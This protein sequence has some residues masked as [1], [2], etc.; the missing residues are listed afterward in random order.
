MVDPESRPHSCPVPSGAE[1][2]PPAQLCVV[3]LQATGLDRPL[4]MRGA[5]PCRQT[6]HLGAPF[7]S[8][9]GER[10][11]PSVWYASPIV[12]HPSTSLLPP[13]AQRCLWDLASISFA[14]TGSQ[15]PRRPLWWYV[16]T[17]LEKARGV[18]TATGTLSSSRRGGQGKSCS[19][20][21]T[22]DDAVLEG[23]RAVNGPPPPPTRR[24]R[25][26]LPG[27]GAATAVCAVS[28]GRPAATD[29]RH[30]RGTNALLGCHRGI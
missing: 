28:G 10:R 13:L 4:P 15:W 22:G 7:P 17:L 18:P 6:P 11:R 19:V 12:A 23:K 14:R 9:I 20:R 21:A 2:P 8:P 5:C 24:P 27:N 30:A 26:L 25:A 1:A 16:R 29:G 3:G